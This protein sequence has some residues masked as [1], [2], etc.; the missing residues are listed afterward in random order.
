VLRPVRIVKGLCDLE[1]LG[2]RRPGCPVDEQSRGPS[3]CDD[4]DRRHA[5]DGTRCADRRRAHR[6]I[7]SAL[8]K[9]RE[10]NAFAARHPSDR[11]H[12]A[13]RCRLPRR[14]LLEPVRDPTSGQVVGDSSIVTVSP[15][16]IRMRC[17]RILPDT[18]ARTLWPFS[19]STRTSRWAA[20]RPPWPAPRLRLLCYSFAS[21]FIG[22]WTDAQCES[23]E[24]QKALRTRSLSHLDSPSR[25]GGS[26]HSRE[27]HAFGAGLM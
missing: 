15:G 18:W 7:E 4:G 19:I 21:P 25:A 14:L 8:D 10:L 11:R 9:R 5:R 26:G 17:I 16:K 23:P 1:V 13:R 3:G 6:E 24:M 20:A 27:Y 2:V 12:G 22:V